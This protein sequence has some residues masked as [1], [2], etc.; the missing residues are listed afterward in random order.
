M[1]KFDNLLEAEMYVSE[2]NRANAKEKDREKRQFR[3][4]WKIAIFGVLG[5]GIAGFITSLL[6]WLLTTR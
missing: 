2:V 4:N 6:F 3:H 1:P 5:G